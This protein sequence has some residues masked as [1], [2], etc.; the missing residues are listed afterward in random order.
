MLPS[1][2]RQ[3]LQG[4][5]LDNLALPDIAIG[6]PFMG[7]DLGN[8]RPSFRRALLKCGLGNGEGIGSSIVT[9]NQTSHSQDLPSRLRD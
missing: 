7:D 8:A 5:D 1:L 3:Y 4:V 9:P 6:H 2:I